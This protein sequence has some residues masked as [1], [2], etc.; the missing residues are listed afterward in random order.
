MKGKNQPAP[1]AD[2]P[3]TWCGADCGY[4]ALVTHP[5]CGRCGADKPLPGKVAAQ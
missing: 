4:T 5:H 1:I 3:S 2:I